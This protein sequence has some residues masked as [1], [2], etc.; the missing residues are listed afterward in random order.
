MEV[1]PDYIKNK[2]QE[3]TDLLAELIEIPSS[4]IMFNENK[5]MEVF[6]SSRTKGNPYHVGD[7]E[8]WDGLYCETVIKS[9][10]EL[11]IPNALNDR[12]WDKNP[13]IKLGM[14]SYLGFPINYPDKKPFG[15]ICVLDKKENEFSETH[16]KLIQQFRD[17]IENDLSNIFKYASIEV[18]I[19]KLSEA[20]K[21]S[22]NSIVITDLKGNIEYTNPKFTEITGYTA[23]EVLGKNP[24]I[25]NSG[26]QSKEFYSNM[27]EIISGGEIWSGEFKNK[28]K[29]GEFYWEDSTISPIKN[30]A[31]EIINYLA[32]KRDISELKEN[33]KLLKEKN[34]E[35]SQLSDK[36]T[37]KN[38]Q[39]FDNKNKF[40]KLFD[41][42]PVSIMEQDFS[43]AIKLLNKKKAETSDIE[44]Y[45]NENLSFVKKCVSKIEV[46]NVNEITL[47]LLGVKNVEELKIH[48]TK[49]NTEKSYNSLKN[50]LVS[51]ALGKKDFYG[52][53]EFI[54][55]DG[56]ILHA[57]IKSTM[58]DENGKN[59]ASI[60][61]ITEIT[62]AKEE[63]IKAKEI[64]ESNN[65]NISAILEGT[66]NSIW[67]FDQNYD[68]LYINQTFQKEFENSFGV[69]LEGGVNLIDA[70]P[71]ELRPLWKP[72]YDK[73]LNNEQFTTED[74]VETVNGIIYIRVTF[75]PIIKK[76]QVVGG[77]CM[78]IDI[79]YQKLAEKELLKAKEKAQESE[80]RLLEAQELSHVGSWEYIVDTDTVAWSKE[81]YNIFEQ[82]YNL[83]PPKFS[84]Q[85]KLY[86]EESFARLQKAVEDCVKREIPYEIGLDIFTSRGSIK[87]IISK[88]KIKKDSNNKVIG[89]YGTAQD[90]TVQKQLDLELIHAKEQAE[91]SDKLKSAFLANMSHEIRTPMNGILGFS[92]L[93]KSPNLSGDQQQKYIEVIEKSG[94][95][96]LNIINDIVDI[97]KI[98]AGLMD[99]NLNESNINEQIEY[100]NTFFKPEVEAKG[101]QLFF[102][103]TLP[104]KEATIKTDIEKL[105]A[106]LTNLVKNAI[107]YS[108]E[109]SIEFGYEKKGD[110]LEFFVK[111]TGIGIPKDRQKAIFERFVQADIKDKMARQG[112]GLG[113]SIT[114]SY[115]EMLG[116]K[117]WVESEEG[118][119]STFYFTLPYTMEF[120]VENSIKDIEVAYDMANQV[121]NLKILIAEDDEVSSE[122]LSV[123]VSDISHEIIKARTGNEAV[124]ICRNNSDIDL[125]LMDI[126]MPEMN[127]YEATRQIREFNKDVIIIAQTAYGL[128]GDRDKSLDAGCN[129]YITKPINKP[130]LD[131]LIQKHN[132]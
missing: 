119:G 99:V 73:V 5:Y 46:K 55:S 100:I 86:T 48:F 83:P 128:T 124:E 76:S 110:Y 87:H 111:D 115:I 42:S 10:M 70:L 4:L 47:L 57:M 61:E 67:A 19:K 52:E 121:K 54:K 88:G 97:S 117:I 74:A 15:T 96:M 64:A 13:D 28:K 23:E 80:K 39:L 6:I 126:Q 69:R 18:E 90:V 131:S 91:E 77:S 56:T 95:R 60:V 33:E 38:R 45:L 65:A 82:P 2:W 81:L 22:A 75:N 101:M 125:I 37:E 79:S 50:E 3:I 71:Q 58:I 102:K 94:N 35:L 93:L 36:L 44:T 8:K 12:N 26:Q 120:E 78:G 127:G 30:D 63:L 41:K 34:I 109:G 132:Y 104:A 51:I 92:E 107:K 27:W 43:E 129:D 105:F 31:G 112:A 20:V 24:N 114:K 7:K 25:L 116:G 98:E 130:E 123:I 40:K 62:K 59:I 32:I 53:T 14:I 106:I 118:I 122:L 16:I 17:I 108:N 1:L 84:K 113:L 9:Q 66:S 103:N 49:T 11:L 72:R 89:S 85:Q 29:N 68:I 21:Q